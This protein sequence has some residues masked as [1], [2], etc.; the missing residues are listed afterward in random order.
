MRPIEIFTESD[1]VTLCAIR[2]LGFVGVGLVGAGLIVGA[3]PAEI[4][5]GVAAVIGAVGGSI[6]LKGDGIDNTK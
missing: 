5:L 3:A 1:N 6:K 2:I 4:G